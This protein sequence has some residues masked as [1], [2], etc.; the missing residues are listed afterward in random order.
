MGLVDSVNSFR[1]YLFVKNINNQVIVFLHSS[2][3]DASAIDICMQLVSLSVFEA[4]QVQ[5]LFV[6]VLSLIII[7]IFLR[8]C[9]DLDSIHNH[10]KKKLNRQQNSSR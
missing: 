8:F 3:Q 4:K 10:G 7:L 5:R 2:N 1:R 6:D 9:M